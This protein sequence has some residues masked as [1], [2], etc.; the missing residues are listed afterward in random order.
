M[1][2]RQKFTRGAAK[3]PMTSSAR[4]FDT[5]QSVGKMGTSARR[6]RP[7]NPVIQQLARQEVPIFSTQVS[8]AHLIL[9]WLPG[10]TRLARRIAKVA[11]ELRIRRQQHAGI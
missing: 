10:F 6:K 1:L 3:A 4:T 2:P 9:V 11:E 5:T 7:P 8:N